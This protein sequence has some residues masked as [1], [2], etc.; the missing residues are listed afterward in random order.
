[1][2]GKY[3]LSL[4]AFCSL[5]S[6]S[7]CTNTDDFDLG[8]VLVTIKESYKEDFESNRIVIENFEW[9]N[10]SELNYGEWSLEQNAGYMAVI[11]KK[12]GVK[13]V[14]DAI[15][16]FITLNFIQSAQK[17]YIYRI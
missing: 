14:E 17:N 13:K 11:L 12:T 3:L 15:E 7:A 5:F 2:F 8:S 10:I 9:E 6:L 4:L 1:M 16:H